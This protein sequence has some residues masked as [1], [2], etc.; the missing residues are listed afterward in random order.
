MSMA[1][2]NAMKG[3]AALREEVEEERW[4]PAVRTDLQLLL[5]ALLYFLCWGRASLY[6]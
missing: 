4:C 6:Q 5:A 3:A 2:V 1:T